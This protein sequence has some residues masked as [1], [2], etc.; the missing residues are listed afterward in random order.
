MVTFFIRKNMEFH[1]RK[2]VSFVLYLMIVLTFLGK[3]L[4][5][6]RLVSR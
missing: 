5:L 1:C 2:K 6:Y 3:T 4:F